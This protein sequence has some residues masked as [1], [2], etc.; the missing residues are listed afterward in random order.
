[1]RMMTN[2]DA[3]MCAMRVDLQPELWVGD[4]AAAVEYYTRAFD[5]IVEHRVG[6]PSDPDGVVQLS[7]GGARFWVSGS[8]Q[9]LGRLDAKSVGGATARFLLV[10]DDPQLF[11]DAAVQ[12]GGRLESPLAQEHGWLLGRVVDPFGHEWEVG[13]P[14]DKWLPAYPTAW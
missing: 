7:V 5:A 2:H 3:M 6:G 12:A 11:M 13:H 10:V 14:L 9:Q 1:M 4:T 8:A